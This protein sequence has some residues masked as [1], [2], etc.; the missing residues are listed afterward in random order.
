[1]KAADVMV[2]KVIT[3]TPETGVEAIAEILLANHISA[4]P[5]VDAQ[6]GVVGIV[7][8]GDLIHRTET[9]TERRRAWWLQLL[10]ANETLEQE[11]IKAHA[12]KAADLMTHPA[13][14]VTPDT[15]LDEIAALLERHRIKRVPVVDRENLVGIVSRA[16]LVQALVRAGHDAAARPATDDSALRASLQKQL[17]GHPWWPGEVNVV[18]RD[19]NIE[20]WGIVE[21]ETEKDAVKVAVEELAETR[22]ID[23]HL[24]IRARMPP[25]V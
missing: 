25:G 21:S 8:E 19:G 10:T 5:V 24:S 22:S 14:T 7:S 2:S 11:F 18:V 9:K 17:R 3:V 6:G 16:N 1:M 23:D 12:R 4:V 13:I 15:P 20:L